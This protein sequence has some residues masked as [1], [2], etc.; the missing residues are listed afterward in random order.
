MDEE[1]DYKV[2]FSNYGNASESAEQLTQKV[3][4]WQRQGWVTQGGMFPVIHPDRATTFAMFQ[5]MVF[6][7]EVQDQRN[8]K[9]EAQEKLDAARFLNQER[10]E[11]MIK[12]L[13]LDGR[14]AATLARTEDHSKFHVSLWAYAYMVANGTIS[15]ERRRGLGR[16]G[17]QAVLTACKAYLAKEKTDEPATEEDET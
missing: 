4:A 12:P 14:T 15:L 7:K 2:V 10:F 16:H 5:T 3:R 17:R 1:L 8:A 13:G 9:A 11:F 6:P